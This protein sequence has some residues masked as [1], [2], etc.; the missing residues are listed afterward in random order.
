MPGRS[1]SAN[2]YRY[3]F[4]Q[5]SE[6]DDEITGVTGSHITTFYR[7]FDTRLLIPW[8]PDPVFQPWQSPY[9]YMDGNPIWF[10]DPRGDVIGIGKGK[11]RKNVDVKTDDEGNVNLTFEKGT[12]QKLQDKFNKQ[13]LP[14]LEAMAKSSMGREDIETINSI[15]NDVTI[16]GLN[17]SSKKADSF[18]K[19]T[20]KE[21]IDGTR[22]NVLITPFLGNAE[23]Q[24]TGNA[25]FAEVL[26]SIMTVEIGHLNPEQRAIDNEH[27]NTGSLTM[28]QRYTSLLNRKTTYRIKFRIENNITIDN[29]VFKHT[30]A[31][32]IKLNDFNQNFK[33]GLSH[34][35]LGCAE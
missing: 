16:K 17:K 28:Q 23:A 15:D 21:L 6:K 12:S 20:G 2:S 32:K 9:S 3:G 8:S 5:G 7:E 24:A 13:S 31:Y 18:I 30:D 27:R 19:Q 26:G 29:S 22:Q 25:S 11:K 33:D 35:S 14:T 4:N 34:H 1:F 10:N